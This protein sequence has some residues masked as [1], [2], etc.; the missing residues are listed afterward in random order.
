MIAQR[1]TPFRS[2]KSFW[3]EFSQLAS[4]HKAINLGQGAPNFPPPEFVRQALVNA[5]EGN[6][7]Q[8]C[9]SQGHPLLLEALAKKYSHLY[10]QPVKNHNVIIGVGAS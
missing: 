7:H 9:P 1:L 2:T 4:H 3:E 10:N 6:Y 5:A 8:Y